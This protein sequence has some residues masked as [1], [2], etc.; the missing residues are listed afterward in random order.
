MPHPSQPGNITVKH[1]SVMPAWYTLYFSFFLVW[2]KQ[3]LL[4]TKKL[5]GT[6]QNHCPEVHVAEESS[7]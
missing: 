2:A 6:Y 1:V 3:Y 5:R 7:V 4:N